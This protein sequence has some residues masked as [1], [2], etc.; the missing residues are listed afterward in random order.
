[1]GRFC[2][3]L[4]SHASAGSR[5]GAKSGNRIQNERRIFATSLLSHRCNPV[6]GLESI[7]R[8]S[9]LGRH[10]RKRSPSGCESQPQR[11]DEQDWGQLGTERSSR[12]AKRPRRIILS[13][14]I[15]YDDCIL[16]QFCAKSFAIKVIEWLRG[17][18]ETSS[19]IRKAR[20]RFVQISSRYVN[21]DRRKLSPHLFINYKSTIQSVERYREN[22]WLGRANAWFRKAKIASR[23]REGTSRRDAGPQLRVAR[24]KSF[25]RWSR[26]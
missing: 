3:T 19:I 2:D 22:T 17:K 23:S 4:A 8:N 21:D 13:I 24:W 18:C 20:Q 26:D 11:D 6:I 1:M 14:P 5:R 16:F 12:S 10:R 15:S 25:Q 9:E 7:G